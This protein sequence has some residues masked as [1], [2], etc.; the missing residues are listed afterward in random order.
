MAT[1]ERINDTAGHLELAD[2]SPPHFVSLEPPLQKIFCLVGLFVFPGLLLQAARGYGR[3]LH[4][5]A[6]GTG[7][8]RGHEPGEHEE[9]AEG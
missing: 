9:H 2:V 3:E 8:W 1:I 6:A 5:F 7:G 4:D